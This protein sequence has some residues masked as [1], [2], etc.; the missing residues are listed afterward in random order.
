[1]ESAAGSGYAE[2]S[3]RLHGVS[4]GMASGR[5]AERGQ[6]WTK[7][8]MSDIQGTLLGNCLASGPRWQPPILR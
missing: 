6:P 1:M 4:V 3:G 7:G 2:G 8:K 5:G